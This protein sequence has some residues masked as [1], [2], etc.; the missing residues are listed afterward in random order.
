MT[1]LYSR[2]IHYTIERSIDFL[3][4]VAALRSGGITLLLKRRHFLLNLVIV[5]AEAEL[6][7]AVDAGGEGRGLV[8]REA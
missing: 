6:D 2:L 1:K 4:L 3:H 7:H 8:E 5:N